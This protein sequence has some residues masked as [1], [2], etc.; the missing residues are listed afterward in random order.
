[1][2]YLMLFHLLIYAIWNSALRYTYI[3][4]LFAYGYLHCRWNILGAPICMRCTTGS[5]VF[6]HSVQ[7][8]T[9]LYMPV[10][11]CCCARVRAMRPDCELIQWPQIRARENR[12]FL[13]TYARD[14]SKSRD[15]VIC[16]TL[17]INFKL[18]NHCCVFADRV[19][20]VL[21]ILIF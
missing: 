15:Y 14:R 3:V 9:Y 2:K 6:P 21:L 16:W 11:V 8:C 7:V 17:R 19:R 13:P 20:I 12:L 10:C 5:T 4:T 18:T 1:M